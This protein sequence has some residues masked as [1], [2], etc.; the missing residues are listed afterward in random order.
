M[1]GPGRE[2]TTPT[3]CNS[4]TT[5]TIDVR[6]AFGPGTVSTRELERGAAK[7]GLTALPISIR[8]G[9]IYIES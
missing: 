8:G 1:D 4:R 5:P 9:E 3:N 6:V 2:Q 7:R